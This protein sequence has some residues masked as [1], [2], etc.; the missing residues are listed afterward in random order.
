MDPSYNSKNEYE[1]PKLPNKL[2]I[3]FVEN[4]INTSEDPIL[5]Q[6]I[7]KEFQKE[8]SHTIKNSY[9]NIKDLISIED[10]K[11]NVDEN[12]GN[13]VN[14][15]DKE[16]LSSTKN[17]SL[18][19]PKNNIILSEQDDEENKFNTQ[20]L[21]YD[22]TKKINDIINGA[23]PEI[24]KE[25]KIIS[26]IS[27]Y[28]NELLTPE[29]VNGNTIVN[30][31]NSI[32][33]DENEKKP[34]TE[35]GNV[36][37]GMENNI[38]NNIHN[39]INNINNSPNKKDSPKK[40]KENSPKKKETE[41]KNSDNS[42]QVINNSIKIRDFDKLESNKS[43]KVRKKPKIGY[44]IKE[45][46]VNKN[47]IN[48]INTNIDS[49]KT[50]P[51]KENFNVFNLLKNTRE[52]STEKRN[53]TFFK[54]AKSV[55][56]L[57]NQIF[58][59][60]K[61]KTQ[62]NT[63]V[64]NENENETYSGNISI[65]GE[66]LFDKYTLPLPINQK[67][68]RNENKI[69]KFKEYKNKTVINVNK[70][71]NYVKL[72]NNF[73]KTDK[74]SS[75]T[76][77]KNR[78]LINLNNSKNKP[79]KFSS[80]DL[81]IIKNEDEI[82][83]GDNFNHTTKVKKIS[84]NN[85][86]FQK[87]PLPREKNSASSMNMKRL[88][89]TILYK[90]APLRKN[91]LNK[92]YEH[93]K[94]VKKKG[95]SLDKINPFLNYESSNNILRT[96]N[97]RELLNPHRLNINNTS[98]INNNKI[99]ATYVK[100]NPNYYTANNYNTNS[101]MNIKN[102]YEIFSPKSYDS[103][104]NNDKN[105]NNNLITKIKRNSSNNVRKNVSQNNIP[106]NN[107]L[108]FEERRT[109]DNITSSNFNAN[110]RQS[111]Q[112]TISLNIEDLL[113]FEEKLFEA[114][115]SLKETKKADNQCFDIWNYYFNCSLYQK[116]EKIFTNE[117]DSQLVRISV[118]YFLLSILLCYEFSFDKEIMNKI[119]ILLLEILQLTHKNLMI[120]Y[121]HILNKIYPISWNNSWVIYLK[122]IVNSSKISDDRNNNNSFNKMSTIDKIVFYSDSVSKKIRSLLVNHKTKITNLIFFLFSKINKK[123]YDEINDFFVEY[124][125]RP[126]NYDGCL[127]ANIFLKSNPNFRT[128]PP[129]YLR[130]VSN[131]PY[132]LILDL[133]ETL[134]SF[135]VAT[136]KKGF[137]RTRPFLF[138][139]LEEI[140]KY[141]EIILFTTAIQSYANSIIN[142]IEYGRKYFD[143][144]FYRQHCIIIGN[145]FVKDINRIGR[146][147]DST[148]IVDNMPQNFKL[149]KENGIV[150][151]SFWGQDSEDGALFNLIPIL[152]EIARSEGDVRIELVKYRDEIAKKVTSSIYK[153][154]VV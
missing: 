84:Q 154:N 135:K 82:I 104:Y 34:E 123:S 116:L 146:P 17:Y 91:S 109:V 107:R 144:V 92:V 25:E 85:F 73:S 68:Y 97:S 14:K 22:T 64:N 45:N 147:L 58:F 98:M 128:L 101:N 114:I 52:N 148:I 16:E 132:T 141:Y 80:K 19:L 78:E 110:F 38:N 125:L 121:E 127:S 122:E 8:D 13:N 151:K 70:N 62:N 145:D 102:Q 106:N 32:I 77:K 4:N 31:S 87:I 44:K 103:N 112:K 5:N 28:N 47:I 118:N 139:F 152:V 86:N 60:D 105:V 46:K 100:K 29:N 149:Q 50:K 124:I 57:K 3:I 113:I 9:L 74:Y 71:N 115:M 138:E 130:N 94:I 53:N 2:E 18:N 48:N 134:V 1:E 61:Y 15:N 43:C 24:K 89:N 119:Y 49:Y 59:K 129:P 133:D 142:A 99:N 111:I 126:D 33:Q 120:I 136:E 96:N 150:I 131:K 75:N 65:G 30:I 6:E 41:K 55:R 66:S 51:K 39:I 37:N 42:L 7:S 36:E 67:V 93:K 83:G 79:K 54:R 35:N 26:D 20:T 11:K 88:E 56:T 140:G 90:R 153:N 143:Y 63:I 108:Y 95:R 10:I 137:V 81:C 40:E 12:N 27:K 69:A 117:E 23:K 76:F 21:T 72:D